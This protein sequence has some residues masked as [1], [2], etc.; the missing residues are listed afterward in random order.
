MTFTRRLSLPRQPEARA[1][2]ASK[3]DG[4]HPLLFTVTFAHRAAAPSS[5]SADGLP[6][7]AYQRFF[8]SAT[9]S[10]KLPFNGNT[11]RDPLEMF[12]PDE[13]N[14]APRERVTRIRSGVVPLDARLEILPRR[15]ADIK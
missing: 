4:A 12:G 6:I 14:R 8:F 11:V 15:A 5:Q 1:K 10:L 9:P 13:N 2:R 7:R 3:D